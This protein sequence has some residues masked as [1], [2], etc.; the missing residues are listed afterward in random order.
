[1]TLVVPCCLPFV[2]SQFRLHSIEVFLANQGQYCAHQCPGL[3][4]RRILPV[5]GVSQR[6]GGG[7]PDAR[8]PRATPTNIQ[9]ANVDWI[10][11][12][13]TQRSGT[14]TLI[15]TGRWKT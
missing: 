8:W 1:M 11:E 13:S 12:Q 4:R 15:L 5:R 14:P 7:S 10:D 6:M 2:Q 9:L 3:G